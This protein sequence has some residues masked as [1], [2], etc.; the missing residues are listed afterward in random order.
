M[1]VKSL[2]HLNQISKKISKKLENGDCIFLIGEIGVGKTTLTR[3]LINNLQNQK[4]L[5]E[6]EVLSPTFNL[7]YEYKIR[8]LKIMHYDLYR[9]KKAEELEHLGIFSENEKTIKIVEWPEL[10]K[11]TL[12]NKLEI[13]LEYGKNDNERKIKILGIGKWKDFENE[14]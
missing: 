1:I 9:I 4:G 3:Y 13:H 11:T 5:K 14:I 12:T 7:L 2:D 6:T 10:I 8:D